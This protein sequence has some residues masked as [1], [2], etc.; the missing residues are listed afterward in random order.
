MPNYILNIFYL[1][2]HVSQ[3]SE[4]KVTTKCNRYPKHWRPFWKM[5]AK[6]SLAVDLSRPFF[7]TGNILGYL[8]K[9]VG[10]CPLFF[11]SQLVSGAWTKVS[12]INRATAI[13]AY[14]FYNAPP[15]CI[16]IYISCCRY[17]DITILHS[18]H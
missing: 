14:M 7:Q 16:Y 11:G 5:A 3:T 15:H 10:C 12:L 2:V 4:L 6:M 9:I 13:T 18:L 1:G 8:K 17:R